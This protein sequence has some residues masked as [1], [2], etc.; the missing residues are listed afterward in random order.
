[1]LACA[2]NLDDDW[3]D[4]I[5]YAVNYVFSAWRLRLLQSICSYTE[6]TLKSSY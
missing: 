4:G 2:N 1:M 6:Q 3:S 5:D